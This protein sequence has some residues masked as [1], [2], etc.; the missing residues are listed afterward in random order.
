MVQTFARGSAD[1]LLSGTDGL[2]WPASEPRWTLVAGP[3][4]GVEIDRQRDRRRQLG[5][6]LVELATPEPGHASY[7]GLRTL[8]S[9]IVASIGGRRPSLVDD[10]QRSLR[11]VGAVEG[12]DSDRRW[13][14]SAST[15]FAITRRISRESHEVG[16]EIDAIARFVLGARRELSLPPTCWVIDD[17]DRWDSPSI[18]CLHRILTL[19]G[20]ED[21][22]HVLAGTGARAGSTADPLTPA[23]VRLGLMERVCGS[24]IA[25]LVDAGGGPFTLAVHVPGEASSADVDEALG[26]QNLERVTALCAVLLAQAKDPAAKALAHRLRATAAAQLE[27][28]DAADAE[29]EAGLAAARSAIDRA[30]LHYLHGLL[31]TKRRGDLPQAALSYEHGLEALR[32]VAPDDPAGQL[33][34]GWLLNGQG[35]VLAL[36]AKQATTAGERRQ[37]NEESLRRE[38]EAYALV[39][40]LDGASAAYLRHNLLANIAF[41]FEIA[42]RF[43]AAIEAWRRAFERFLS[44]SPTFDV[45]FKH[46][47]GLLLAKASQWESARAELEQARATAETVGDRFAAERLD[48]ALGWALAQ[49]GSSADAVQAFARGRAL[50]CALRDPDAYREQVHGQLWCLAA[51]GRVDELRALIEI[52]TGLSGLD[53]EL[54]AVRQQWEAADPSAA[55]DAAGVRLPTPSP[56]MPSYLPRVD[57]QGGSH[58][59][60]NRHLVGAR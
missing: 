33:E 55:L 8:L 20:P 24:D 56:K 13:G 48:L 52:D 28:F 16:V 32:D 6:A 45:T 9:G 58:R 43:D 7:T 21:R 40:D 34:H 23:D 1:R 42:G 25:T 59:D 54:R 38:L 29:I 31:A 35:L 15:L 39:K 57:L 10:F 14:V 30:H 22:V 11:F 47:L 36:E 60:L 44:T 5:W 4:R 46:R 53:A 41:L 51:S 18:R 3:G 19:A 17:L 26:H 50:A 12:A 2:A 27:A 37:L 49:A